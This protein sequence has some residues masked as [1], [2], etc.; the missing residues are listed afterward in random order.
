MASLLLPINT[1]NPPCGCPGLPICRYGDIQ[2]KL[3][4][5]QAQL[6]KRVAQLLNSTVGA[7]EAV[8]QDMIREVKTLAAGAHLVA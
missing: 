2:A 7:A 3:H 6:Q 4:E 5:V 8:L 1:T